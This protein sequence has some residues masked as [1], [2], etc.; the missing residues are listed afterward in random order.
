MTD[1]KAFAE[2]FGEGFL[3]GA[4]GA[5]AVRAEGERIPSAKKFPYPHCTNFSITFV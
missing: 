5:A 4:P 3:Y 2:F 1:L